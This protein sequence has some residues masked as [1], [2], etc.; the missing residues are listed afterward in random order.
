MNRTIFINYKFS[1]MLHTEMQVSRPVLY[2][3]VEVIISMLEFFERS[4]YIDVWNTTETESLAHTSS[5][6]GADK[7]RIIR[8]IM[9]VVVTNIDAF[10]C[11][12][13]SLTLLIHSVSF[14]CVPICRVKTLTTMSTRTLQNRD[15]IISIRR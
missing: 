7:R 13:R 11:D 12:A 6:T 9:R 10:R 5:T 2:L 15:C 8:F 3:S 1:K 4:V 14:V